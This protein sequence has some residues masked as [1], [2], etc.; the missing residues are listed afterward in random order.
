MKKLGIIGSGDLGQL[1]AYHAKTIGNYC[2]AGFFD[3]FK[4]KNESIHNIPIIGAVFP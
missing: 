3:D 1:I 4:K 2:V